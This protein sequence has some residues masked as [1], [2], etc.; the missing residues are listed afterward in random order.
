M[1]NSSSSSTIRSVLETTFRQKHQKCLSDVI[2]WTNVQILLEKGSLLS[3][4]F[5]VFEIA[6][7]IDS[8]IEVLKRAW[9]GGETSKRKFSSITI[10]W[11]SFC[12][13]IK[14][15]Y[16]VISDYEL[17]FFLMNICGFFLQLLF[18]KNY[19]PN[20]PKT[21]QEK[22]TISTNSPKILELHHILKSICQLP[23]F[24]P[25]KI[26]KFLR[27]ESGLHQTHSGIWTHNIHIGYL[28]FLFLT[29][30]TKC[31]AESFFLVRRSTEE[32]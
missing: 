23:I 3:Q 17:E 11:S 30:N 32:S 6:V 27:K 28:D 4:L 14:I 19:F 16:N 25:H 22:K 26:L 9:N 1:W 20:Y 8:I 15:W 29:K 12:T 21:K 31:F 2:F 7:S 13:L 24:N 18:K 10:S 5:T